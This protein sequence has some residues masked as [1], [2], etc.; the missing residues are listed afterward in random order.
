MLFI[1]NYNA[2]SWVFVDPFLCLFKVPYHCCHLKSRGHPHLSLPSRCLTYSTNDLRTA[3]KAT[4]VQPSHSPR[5]VYHAAA[6]VLGWAGQVQLWPQGGS[7]KITDFD[8]SGLKS[9]LSECG[10]TLSPWTGPQWLLSLLLPTPLFQPCLPSSSPFFEEGWYK[11]SGGLIGVIIPVAMLVL[12]FQT[13]SSVYCGLLFPA[14]LS[15]CRS[16]STSWAPVSYSC[17]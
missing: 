16:L 5:L 14:S 2:R 1:E 11:V 6:Q 13:R 9:A 7:R 8:S 15:S 10:T 12:S 4:S 3:R 17:G